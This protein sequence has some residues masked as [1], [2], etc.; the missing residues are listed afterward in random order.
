MM[1]ATISAL[2]AMQCE[3]CPAPTM[4]VSIQVIASWPMV[5]WLA[6]TVHAT[7][8]MSHPP[9]TPLQKKCVHEPFT[10]ATPS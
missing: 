9:I 10:A 2:L 6:V 7:R 8:A 3:K 4:N 5:Q 1:A